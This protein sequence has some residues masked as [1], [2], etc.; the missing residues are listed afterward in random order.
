MNK[1]K[2]TPAAKAMLKKKSIN[3]IIALFRGIFLIGI[4]FV[5]L[6][7]FVT[8]ICFS[9]M[10]IKDVYNPNI[11]FLPR[12]FTL[13]NYVA[14]LDLLD[15][16]KTFLNTALLSFI[17]SIVQLI[18]ALMVGYGFARYNFKGKNFLFT[19]V[20]VGMVI[21]PDLLLLPRFLQF[22]FFD[23][24]GILNLFVE[25][26]PSLIDTYWP[27]ILLGITATGLKNGLYIFMMRQYFM[28]FPKVIEEAAFVDG[29]GPIKTFIRIILP[30]SA[31][32]SITIFL[33]S[34]VWQWND[35]I[36]SPVFLSELKVFTNVVEQLVTAKAA[37]LLG[38]SSTT[39]AASL[40]SNAGIVLVFLPLILLY[41]LCQKFFVQS[42]ETSGI[43]G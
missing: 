26:S 37:Q 42:I 12:N 33:F 22:R 27:F 19:T 14:A 20:I 36:Y 3:S 21:P 31:T 15:F 35:S 6:Y 5:V 28:S 9:F 4:C 13:K 1:I 10:Q 32:M 17:T 11:T 2:M 30:S 40:V 23:F 29:A 25:E 34:F 41:S 7:P 24:G 18:S 16:A 39:I 8:K 43:V 38:T